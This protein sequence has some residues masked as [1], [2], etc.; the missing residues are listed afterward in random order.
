MTG[1]AKITMATKPK[2]RPRATGRGAYPSRLRE[3]GLTL[4]NRLLREAA[5]NGARP[6]SLTEIRAWVNKHR[7]LWPNDREVDD[8]IAWVRK[9]RRESRK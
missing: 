4:R 1:K 2:S 5:A 8:F 6:M 7:E 9:T 3:E